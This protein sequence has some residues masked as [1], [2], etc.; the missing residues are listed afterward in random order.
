ML[1]KIAAN[2]DARLEQAGGNVDREREDGGVEQEGEHAMDQADASHRFRGDVDIRRLGRGADDVGKIEKVAVSGIVVI[3]KLDAPRLTC[4][5]CHEI[6]VGIMYGKH[7]VS[8]GPRSQDGEQRQHDIEETG[9]AMQVFGNR[10][11]EDYGGHAGDRTDDHQDQYKQL[12]LVLLLSALPN[13]IARRAAHRNRS[14]HKIQADTCIPTHQYARNG[15][16]D[17]CVRHQQAYG[18]PHH[19]ADEQLRPGA[20]VADQRMLAQLFS[21]LIGAQMSRQL[22]AAGPPVYC[23]RTL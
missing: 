18:Q 1:R 7:H 23:C 13:R 9:A 8:E 11:F 17:P 21:L 5:T 19:D 4:H 14:E 16:L 22:S 10:Q 2:R 15:L 6:V 3:G 12:A 20:H